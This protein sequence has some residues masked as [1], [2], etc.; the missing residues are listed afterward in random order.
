MKKEQTHTHACRPGVKIQHTKTK[1]TLR[2]VTYIVFFCGRMPQIVLV[3]TY[4]SI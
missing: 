4:L 3:K 1:I 2:Q